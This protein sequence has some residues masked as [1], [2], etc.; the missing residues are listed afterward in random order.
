VDNESTPRDRLYSA[1]CA[2]SR[3]THLSQRSRE[4]RV[5]K[6]VRR[7]VTISNSAES[8][9]RDILIALKISLSPIR[10]EGTITIAEHDAPC[11]FLF[12]ALQADLFFALQADLRRSAA[13]AAHG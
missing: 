13:L 8:G 1:V 7:W 11:S 2:R 4:L 3:L 10:G 5:S 6:R 12:F 9:D